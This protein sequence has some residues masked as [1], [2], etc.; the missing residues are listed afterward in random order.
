MNIS[1]IIPTTNC[2]REKPFVFCFSFDLRS[3][4][5]VLMVLLLVVWYPVNKVKKRLFVSNYS[6]STFYTPFN[7]F[8]WRSGHGAVTSSPR[9]PRWTVLSPPRHPHHVN[10]VPLPTQFSTTASPKQDN[11]SRAI[12]SRRTGRE[13]GLGGTERGACSIIT[14]IN[15]CRFNWKGRH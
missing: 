11:S 6:Q 8:V 3:N 10:Q 15:S 13:G 7:E 12:S 2:Q 4:S 1:I 5:S 9:Y 14:V